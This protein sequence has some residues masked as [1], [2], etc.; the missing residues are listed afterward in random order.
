MTAALPKKIEDLLELGRANGWTVETE[1]YDETIEGLAEAVG[2]GFARNLDDGRA[3]SFVTAYGKRSEGRGSWIL[4]E[5]EKGFSV[6]AEVDD[7]AVPDLLGPDLS[8][9][10]KAVGDLRYWLEHPN[11]LVELWRDSKALPVRRSLRDR[12]T[13]DRSTR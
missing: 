11:E 4:L 6:F 7:P 3:L 12:I 2:L 10:W 5:D 1:P 8:R 9:R 13:S